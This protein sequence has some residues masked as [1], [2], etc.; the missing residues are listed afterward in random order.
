YAPKCSSATISTASMF[1]HGA[2]VLQQFPALK[3]Y[4]KDLEQRAL[5]AWQWYKV[6][7]SKTDCDSQEIQSGD[8][9]QSLEEQTG[10]AVVAAIYLLA[11]T[12]D[13]Q[14]T[15]N[16]QQHLN[17]TRPF[18]DDTWS[19]YRPQEGD[20]LL[21]YAQLPQADQALKTQ[22]L[23]RFQQMVT[24][25]KDSYGFSSTLDPYRAYMPDP[26]YHWGS[27]S[28]KANYGNTNFD[29]I[30]FGVDSAH[31]NS[32]EIRA[33][34]HLHYLHGVNP[35]GIVY[36]TNMYQYRAE[37]SANE[38]YHSW[39]GKGIYDNALT[40]K[41]GPAP[42]YLTGGPNKSYTGSITAVKTQPPM[43][44]YVDTNDSYPVNSW[45]ITEPG[46][47]YQSSY[48]KLLSKFIG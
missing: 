38:M 18:L 16:I 4:A 46:I 48:I 28:V 17:S 3:S 26:Q 1:A 37:N 24:N 21:F 36:L 8:A 23:Q 30:A 22:I 19:R 12:A 11:L 13:P 6:N 34:D 43:K 47:Y 31:R 45:E 2:L 44:A 9:D 40:S 39:L 5:Q 42:G 14:Y 25:N 7:P 35:L 27:N 41:S 32:Y 10:T 33:L 15:V 20:A 29:A